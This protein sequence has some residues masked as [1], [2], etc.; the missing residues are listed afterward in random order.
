M[1]SDEVPPASQTEGKSYTLWTKA[2]ESND[3]VLNGEK[4]NMFPDPIP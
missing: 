3:L 4:S 1:V 2:H